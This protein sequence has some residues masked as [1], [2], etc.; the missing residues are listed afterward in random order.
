MK[1]IGSATTTILS[2][3]ASG[4]GMQHGEHGS[5]TPY[6]TE[7][8][9]AWLATQSPDTV[10]SAAV[11]RA[12]S[13]GAE[14]KVVKAGHATYDKN[15]NQAG[16]VTYARGCDVHGP[17]DARELA[18]DDLVKF[19]TPAPV[20]MIEEWLAELSVITARRG[21]DD[22]GDELRLTAYVARLG[23]YPADIARKAVLDH[24]WTF[25]PAWSEV[26]AVCE[27]LYSPRK[28]M[29]AA[30]KSGPKPRE[31]EWRMATPEEKQRAQDLVDA[32]FPNKPEAERKAAVDEA[33]KGYCMKDI[34]HE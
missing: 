1:P 33:M 7:K 32:M 31:P 26:E 29:I 30:L 34:P 21:D 15:G 3:A 25:W 9:A 14:L 16:F 22:V 18:L 28:H 11:L 27:R 12:S 6:D 23:R 8:A 17:Q 4:I 2:K 13:R 10:D 24:N 5:V 19:C 20:R